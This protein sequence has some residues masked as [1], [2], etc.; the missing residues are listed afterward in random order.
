[1]SVV[2]TVWVSMGMAVVYRPLLMIVFF[3]L[4][5]LKN[6]VCLCKGV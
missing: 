2:M 5:E 3:S 1:M 4:G 6:V